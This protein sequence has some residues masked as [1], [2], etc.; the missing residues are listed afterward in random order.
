MI[1]FGYT[2]KYGLGIPGS[3][4]TYRVACCTLQYVWEYIHNNIDSN[5]GAYS[6]DSWNGNYMSSGLYDNW[7]AETEGYYNQYH[8]NTSF[9]GTTTKAILGQTVTI[10][11]TSNRL[12]AYQSFSQTKDGVTFSHNQG[13][14]DLT[15]SASNDCTAD[16]ISFNSRDYGLYKDSNC[17]NQVRTG[18]SNSNGQIEFNRLAPGTYYVKEL[19]VPNGYLLDTSHGDATLDG[20]EYTLYAK[21]DICNVAGS[22]KYYSA[23]EEIATYTFNSNGV[24][25]IKITTKSTSTNLTFVVSFIILAILIC[26]IFWIFYTYLLNIYKKYGNLYIRRYQK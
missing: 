15:I 25:S 8:G 21:D 19:S 14:N 26:I 13:S 3:D 5:L 23:N 10:T 16:T 4:E 1:Y 9:N 20:T 11:D 17:I 18:M 2:M 7:L 6:S 22:V 12:S 24:A